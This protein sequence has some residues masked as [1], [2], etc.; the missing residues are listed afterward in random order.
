MLGRNTTNACFDVY[1]RFAGHDA[2]DGQS[3]LVMFLFGFQALI[4]SHI[5]YRRHVLQGY[6]SSLKN[7]PCSWHHQ[8][9]ERCRGSAPMDLWHGGGGAWQTA[10]SS[11]GL[12]QLNV[13]LQVTGW[14]PARAGEAG[15]ATG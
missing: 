2:H 6:F 8:Q 14:V 7:F 13:A 15:G 12:G 4:H 1:K 5:C 10:L 3:I 11:G 9:K